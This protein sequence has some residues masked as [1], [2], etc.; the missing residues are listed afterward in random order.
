MGIELEVEKMAEYAYDF[1]RAANDDYDEP[2][3]LFT[4]SDGSLSETG[5]E[6]VTMPATL[7]AF[8][9]LW[10]QDAMDKARDMGARSFRWQNCGFHIHVS[11]SAFMPSHMWKFV[12]FQMRNSELCQRVGQRENSSYAEW[13]GIQDNLSNLPNIVKGKNSNRSRYI[14]INFQRSDTVELRYFKGNILQEAIMKNVE[15][16]DSIYEYTKQL[17]S[18][19]IIARNGLSRRMYLLWLARNVEYYPNLYSFLTSQYP[20][21]EESD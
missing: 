7:K 14:A 2:N 21:T 18:A 4:K 5:V 17:S 8:K 11:R 13:W 16:V 10:P 19:E 9:E 12:R 20:M 1:I 3:F 6:I 15:F